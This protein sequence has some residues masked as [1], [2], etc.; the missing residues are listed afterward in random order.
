MFFTAAKHSL[1]RIKEYSQSLL[2]GVESM[3]EEKQY[4]LQSKF[5]VDMYIIEFERFRKFG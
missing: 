4:T 5:F 2:L 3:Q 1:K